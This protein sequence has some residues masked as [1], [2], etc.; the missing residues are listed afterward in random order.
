MGL[1]PST[2][3]LKAHTHTDT[4]RKEL[5]FIAKFSRVCR[6]FPYTPCPTHPHPPGETNSPPPG[7]IV[8]LCE[9]IL[10]IIIAQSLQLTLGLT[11]GEHSMSLD[12][13]I[14]N[15]FSALKI[16]H[17]LPIHPFLPYSSATTD[18]FPIFGNI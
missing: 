1:M 13:I 11:L 3:T 14:Q 4:H 9:P 17:T 16:L 8:T 12:S 10:H 5:R 18:L 7:A 15:I 6:D 2:P